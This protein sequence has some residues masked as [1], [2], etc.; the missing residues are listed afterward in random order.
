MN[1]ELQAESINVFFLYFHI[2]QDRFGDRPVYCLFSADHSIKACA[3]EE[4]K[5]QVK[6]LNGS[7]P[8]PS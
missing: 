5:R 6:S 3:I 8:P 2:T 7:I 1:N 4:N